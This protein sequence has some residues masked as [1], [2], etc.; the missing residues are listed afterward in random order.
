M[1]IIIGVNNKVD[2]SEKSTPSMVIVVFDIAVT[3]YG[4]QNLKSKITVFFKVFILTNLVDWHP[5]KLVS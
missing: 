1:A 2:L 3:N 5:D 4:V